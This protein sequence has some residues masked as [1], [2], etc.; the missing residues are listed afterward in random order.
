MASDD[1]KKD[2]FYDDAPLGWSGQQLSLIPSSALR[3]DET[4]DDLADKAANAARL[5][6][7]ATVRGRGRPPGSGNKTSS[8]MAKYL[9]ARYASPLIGMAEIAARSVDELAK[10]LNCTKL[11][12]FKMQFQALKELAPY[13]HQKLPTA[14]DLGDIG[15]VSLTIITHY[16]PTQA[17]DG[18][19]NDGFIQVIEHD[20]TAES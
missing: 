7:L 9:N 16:Q 14:I 19:Q 4:G 10:E 18:V 8:E 12:A 1:V 20:D 6:E 5:R 13:M 3:G 2:G 11:D 15:D 17:A